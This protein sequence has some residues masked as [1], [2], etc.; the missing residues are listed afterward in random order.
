MD[1]FIF[2]T[3]FCRRT[4][5]P[6]TPIIYISYVHSNLDILHSYCH[7]FSSR[8][9]NSYDKI[10]TRYF[11]LRMSY[12]QGKLRELKLKETW[13]AWESH[14][15]ETWAKK[16]KVASSLD[17]FSCYPKVLDLLEKKIHW[18]P[19]EGQIKVKLDRGQLG[20]AQGMVL[21]LFGS[22]R[23]PRRGDLVSAFVGSSMR[24]G[25]FAK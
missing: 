7:D 19:I 24:V 1:R 25:Y 18:R 16:M 14:I 23:S 10:K 13:G 21:D 4:T 22:D 2:T 17:K 8:E 6:E 11:R 12:L 5:T 3:A 15:R 20:Q 9:K